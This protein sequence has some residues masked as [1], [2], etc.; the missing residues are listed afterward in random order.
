[1]SG[2]PRVFVQPGSGAPKAPGVVQMVP[3]GL[4]YAGGMR[5]IGMAPPGAYSGGPAPGMPQ[6]HPCLG[7]ATAPHPGAYGMPA[8]RQPQFL[9]MPPGHM[10]QPQVM[11]PQRMQPQQAHL[12]QPMGP[13]PGFGGLQAPRG[14]PMPGPLQLP[15]QGGWQPMSMPSHSGVPP[16]SAGCAGGQSL[17]APTSVLSQRGG[18]GALSPEQFAQLEAQAQR[19]LVDRQRELEELNRYSAMLEQQLVADRARLAAQAAPAG[20][21]LSGVL[22]EITGAANSCAELSTEVAKAARVSA[23]LNAWFKENQSN[24]KREENHISPSDYLEQCTVALQQQMREMVHGWERALAAFADGPAA[25]SSV[26][27]APA[28]APAPPG[29][30]PYAPQHGWVADGGGASAS[31]SAAGAS[32]TV[33]LARS[34]AYATAATSGGASASTAAASLPASPSAAGAVAAAAPAAAASVVSPTSASG[35]A[36]ASAPVPA[37]SPCEAFAGDAAEAETLAAPL[38]LACLSPRAAGAG[39]A[40]SPLNAAAAADFSGYAAQ[41]DGDL[42]GSPSARAPHGFSITEEHRYALDA[43]YESDN[44][45]LCSPTPPG[46]EGLPRSWESFVINNDGR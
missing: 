40:Q 23:Q 8:Q 33:S 34:A 29:A 32:A 28:P 12:Q 10:M 13:H 44:S 6:Q 3:G 45:P 14:L 16:G 19:E 27:V 30:A 42:A 5:P 36:E 15:A 22:T 20:F 41:D 38:D 46:G 25:G 26:S 21:D 17:E 9:Q 43:D 24:M 37:V 39:H 35:R 1:M 4:S 11:P 31:T 7:Y 2:G 18:R